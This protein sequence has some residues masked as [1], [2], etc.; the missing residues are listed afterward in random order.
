VDKDSPKKMKPV[1]TYEL[2]CKTRITW[3]PP[4]HTEFENV[5][6][7]K[8]EILTSDSVWEIIPLKICGEKLGQER[9]TSCDVNLD[10]LSAAPYNIKENTVL[11]ARVQAKNRFGYGPPSD[12]N[13]IGARVLGRPSKMTTLQATQKVVD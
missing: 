9:E 10:F 8:L 3:V 11:I 1:V 6:S 13:V 2:N 5:Q 12:S 4:P 7:Y